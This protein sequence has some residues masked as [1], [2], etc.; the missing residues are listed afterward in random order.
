ME[1]GRGK[2]KV[3]QEKVKVGHKIQLTKKDIMWL[4][5]FA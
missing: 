2:R 4:L 1:I 3:L 5:C